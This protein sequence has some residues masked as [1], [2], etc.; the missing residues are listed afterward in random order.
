MPFTTTARKRR[1]PMTLTAK[2]SAKRQAKQK[3]PNKTVASNTDILDIV[4]LSGILKCSERHVYRLIDRGLVPAPTK[5]G[6]LN[7]WSVR[8]G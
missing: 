8:R 6:D 5:L 4:D 3:A 2:R 1:V 7:R